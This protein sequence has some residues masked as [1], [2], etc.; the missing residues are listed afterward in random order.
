MRRLQIVALFAAVLAALPLL[1]ETRPPAGYQI[2]YDGNVKIR[3]YDGP[4]GPGIYYTV[5]YRL[6]NPN[7]VKVSEDDKIVIYEDGI[8]VDRFPIPTTKVKIPVEVKKEDLTTVLALDVSASMAFSDK[9]GEAKQAAGKFLDILGHRMDTGLILFDDTV[10]V[11]DANR[12]RNP[13]GDHARHKEQTALIRRLINQARPLNGSAYRDATVKAIDMLSF[14]EGRK[15]V[16]LMT[17]GLDVNSRVKLPEVIKRA[18]TIG[19]PVYTVGIGAPGVN[20]V[21]VLDRS[22][23]MAAPANDTDKKPKIKALHEAG[24]KFVQE[25]RPGSRVSLLPFSTEVDVPAPFTDDKQRLISTIRSLEPEGGTSLYD[26]TM[27]AVE[28][29][30]AARPPG[31]RIVVVLTDGKDESPGSRF[32][33][34]AVIERAKEAGIKLYMLGLGRKKEINEKVMTEMARQTGGQ[35]FYVGSAAELISTFEKLSADLNDVEALKELA[36]KTGGKFY[37]ANDVSE[38]QTRFKEVAE[39]VLQ[40]VVKLKESEDLYE[41]EFKSARNVNDG[42]AR[43]ITIVV[44]SFKKGKDGQA[45][46]EESLSER[47]EGHGQVHGLVVPEQ[48][49]V[50]YLVLL[51][52]VAGCLALPAG[53]RGLKGSAR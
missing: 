42:T 44:K 8:E 13:S 31:N 12:F 36:E 41:H 4:K 19:V 50:L 21:L 47:K 20:T 9:I 32:S 38:L 23:S 51:G 26:A 10:A 29:L 52:C 17:D 11:N 14:V 5:R 1:A 45:E 7:N 3:S 2:D 30:V 49:P 33:D 6:S 18:T 27:T 40:E 22:G 48:S 35:Y 46:V 37:R 25:M 16:V 53:L 28:T 43:K 34:R 24:M 39:V 15:A